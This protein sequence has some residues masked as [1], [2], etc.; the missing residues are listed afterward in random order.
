MVICD[1]YN[2]EELVEAAKSGKY[3]SEAVVRT[4]FNR[5]REIFINE[6][7]VLRVSSPIV[8]CGDIHGQ[9]FDLK[10]LFNC[11]GEVPTNRYL[12]LGDY[13]DRGRN[14][15]EVLLWLFSLKVRFPEHIFLL[16]GN[17]EC[18]TITQTYGFYDECLSKYGHSGIWNF[19]CEVFDS[20]PLAA[21]IDNR[22]LCVHGGLSP[23]IHT[24]SEIHSI[25][26]FR[27][28]PLTGPFAD[29]LWSDPEEEVGSFQL[30]SSRGAGVL[31]G[32][33]AVETFLQENQ[34]QLICRSHQLCLEGYKY[35]WDQKLLTIWSAPNYTYSCKNKAAV[36]RF[37]PDGT[38][39]FSVFEAAENPHVQAE[40]LYTV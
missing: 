16:R 33:T 37:I 23:K 34:L 1:K 26:R 6:P 12:F 25:N 40:A 10:S 7:N 19:C 38:C 36:V 30:N 24:I 35:L 22:V 18:R 17:H 21:V 4:L 14:S 13:V 32:R 29:L 9:F 5:V 3:F 15:L 11:Y 39:A 20:I 27:E 28:I 2:P 8:V 31:F